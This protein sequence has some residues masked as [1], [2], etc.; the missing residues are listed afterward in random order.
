MAWSTATVSSARIFS[1]WAGWIRPSTIRRSRERRAISRRTGS[2]QEM[3]TDSGVSSTITSTPAACS[4]ARILRPF[5]PTIRPFISSFGNVTIEVETLA[6]CSEATRWMASVIISRAR[7]SPSDMAS[8]SIW[9]MM[10]A[11]SERAS[12][13]SSA[14]RTARASSIDIWLMRCN[15]SNWSEYIFSMSLA[16]LSI[17]PWRLFRF[18]S[19]NSRRSIR[20]SNSARRFC[21]RSSSRN[22]SA[23]LRC[24]S[25]SESCII[26]RDLSLASSST[27][28]AFSVAILM[29]L[30]ALVF[31]SSLYLLLKTLTRMKVKTPAKTSAPTITKIMS[32]I[33]QLP[34]FLFLSLV[35]LHRFPGRT[36]DRSNCSIRE[37]TPH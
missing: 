1:I 24:V 21:N 8:L 14:R 4:N 33:F 2:K 29:I 15:S 35:S 22:I 13:S 23:R 28:F 37:T 5:L 36:D 16:R 11:I 3:V 31:C 18:C 7:F 34:H 27:V 9:R 32:S 10:R 6:T 17:A 19:R 20:W 30:S 25:A 12:F 26:L